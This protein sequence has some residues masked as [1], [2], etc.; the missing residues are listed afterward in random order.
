MRI[1]DCDKIFQDLDKKALINNEKKK[2]ATGRAHQCNCGNT[3][4]LLCKTSKQAFRYMD[5]QLLELILALTGTCNSGGYLHLK[6]A[7]KRTNKDMFKIALRKIN[8]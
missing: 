8:Y 1:I 7:D 3:L 4:M 6:N 2:I 5:K